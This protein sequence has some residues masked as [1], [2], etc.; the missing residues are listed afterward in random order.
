MNRSP[1]ACPPLVAAALAIALLA[2][3][4]ASAQPGES[5]AVAEA[6]FQQARDLVKQ[7]RYA[8][9]CPKLAESQRLDPKLGT[10]LNLAVCNEKL[11]KI[12]TAW[13]EYTSAAAI[14]RREGQREREDFSREQIAALEK[15]LARVIL[16]VAA[17]EAGLSVTL[18]DQPMAGAVLGTPLPIDPGKHRVSATAPGKKAWSQDIDVPAKKTE[19]LVSIPA[20]EAAPAAPPPIPPA[21]A[22]PAIPP[23]ASPAPPPPPAVTPPPVAT[24]PSTGSTATALMASGFSIGAL[25]VVVGTI[26]GA[27]TLSQAGT[28]HMS[29]K[30]NVCPSGDQINIDAANRVANISNASFAIGA[31]GVVV[32]VVGVFMR[33]GQPARPGAAALTLT[34]VIGPGVVGLRGGF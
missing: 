23:A 3:L 18:D 1:R 34:P 4:R 19:V 21:P 7:E 9:A 26:T 13:A 14:A 24:P 27:V 2:P 11:G 6:L 17:P 15:K 12:A 30:N 22:P 16:Q 31:A 33:P 5:A 32:G 25:G 28:L 29:C 10:L 20:L 8:E